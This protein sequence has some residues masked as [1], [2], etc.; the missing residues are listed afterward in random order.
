MKIE[1]MELAIR[2]L[3]NGYEDNEESGVFAYDGGLW[4]SR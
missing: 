1:L 2:D 4:K 3:T